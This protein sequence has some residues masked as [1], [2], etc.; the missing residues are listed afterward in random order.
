MIGSWTEKI[1]SK[2]FF[3]LYSFTK[4]LIRT[5]LLIKK[6]SLACASAFTSLLCYYFLRALHEPDE[7]LHLLRLNSISICIMLSIWVH[8]IVIVIFHT[9]KHIKYIL[10][11]SFVDTRSATTTDFHEITFF[12]SSSHCSALHIWGK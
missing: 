8:F 6:A 9:L 11:V 10:L 4:N 2:W 7:I 1:H 12:S 3:F 5:F